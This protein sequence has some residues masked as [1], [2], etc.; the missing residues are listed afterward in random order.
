VA[1][2]ADVIGDVEIG[3]ESSVWFQAVI[4]G[5]VHSIR[6]GARTN[7]QDQSMLHVTRKRSPLVIGDDVTVGHR[8]TLHGCKVGNRVLV[9]M[10]SII[11]DDAEIGDDCIIGAG[12]LVTQ[13]MKVPP[14]HMVLGLPGKVIRR[15]K[16]EELA[17]LPESARNY[18]N[19]S[20][21]YKSYVGG[22]PRLGQNN[23]DLETFE[24]EDEGEGE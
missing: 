12:A 19:D 16:P 22:P 13:G 15:L 11:L 21:G 4:R 2:S 20:R 18:V 10:G 14:G 23:A 1:P 5:D 7:I 17:Y 6:I 9:G 8:V 3:D 24:I